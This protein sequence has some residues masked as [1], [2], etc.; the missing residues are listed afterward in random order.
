[1]KTW[2]MGMAG[3]AVSVMG[4]GAAPQELNQS[5]FT[6]VINDVKVKSATAVRP[7]TVNGVVKSPEI[8]QTGSNS[9]AELQAP[10][11]TL[12][13][14]GANTIFS[15]DTAG[16]GIDL[17]Q[18]TVLFHS[19]EGKGGGTIRTA[20]ATAAVTGTTIM[21]VSTSNG[22]FKLLV[23]EGKARARLPGGRGV[24]LKAGQLTFIIPGQK[25]LGPILTFDL[26]QAIERANMVKGF[27]K[28][29][30]SKDKIDKEVEKQQQAYK[31]GKAQ[32]TDTAILDSA[33]LDGVQIAN[34]ELIEERL[35]V[36]EEEDNT[37]SL[38]A[39]AF[40]TDL[41]INSATLPPDRIFEGTGAF[42]GGLAPETEEDNPGPNNNFAPP[43]FDITKADRV[44]FMPANNIV[45]DTP[46]LDLSPFAG[47]DAAGFLAMNSIY[48]KQGFKSSGFQNFLGFFASNGEM[49]FSPGIYDF[50]SPNNPNG[51]IGVHFFSLKGIKLDG[52]NVRNNSRAL[53]F[54]SD[55]KILGADAGFIAQFLKMESLDSID[56]KN[57]GG[58]QAVRFV[59]LQANNL[60]YL[61]GNTAA[62]N[63]VWAVDQ[64]TM[65][66][67]SVRLEANTIVLK[68]I[69]FGTNADLNP[70]VHLFTSTGNWQAN[71]VQQNGWLNLYNVQYQ[72]NLGP[73]TN[74]TGSGGPG[75]VIGNMKSF[76]R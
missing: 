35:N 6:Q 45:F 36:L 14:V 7:G 58:I 16:R 71:S 31:S 32:P 55:G 64:G 33:G 26:K 38:I 9:R 8:V 50:S 56:L 11:Q 44:F 30:A 40:A 70:H 19:P 66:N 48:F 13:R 68:N 37:L 25:Q 42:V 51:P 4:A 74:V 5:T 43:K 12:T 65:L 46:T 27:S 29:I 28:P 52:A 49:V 57:N 10:D 72:V 22:G 61:S 67:P 18:G 1:M 47:G 39:N 62:P 76:Q 15:F 24:D 69:T 20:A 73:A 75:V 60:I 21:V 3:M 53:T 41:L 23:L 2:L 17:K 63:R 34:R 54:E 59:D